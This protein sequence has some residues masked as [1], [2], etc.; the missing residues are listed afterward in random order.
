MSGRG[1]AG[2]RGQAL[3]E[4]AVTLPIMIVLFLGFLAAGVAAQGY[5]DL[6]TAV[7]LAAAANAT[8]YA[9]D[10][11]DADRFAT[12]TFEATVGHD[13]LL[14]SQGLACSG[15]YGAGGTV[16]CQGSAALEFSRTPLAVVVPVDPTLT[17]Q[18]SAVRSPYRSAR[19]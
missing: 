2:G 3:V 18:A 17:A 14:R 12:S 1:G 13:S 15:D 10:R 19:P 11:A 4:T 8:A 9:D 6:E 16:T 5:V 7:A